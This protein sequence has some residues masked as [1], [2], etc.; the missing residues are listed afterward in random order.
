[1]PNSVS[2]PI[3]LRTLMARAYAA[4]PSARRFAAGS[5]A[6]RHDHPGQEQ[7]DDDDEDDQQDLAHG[8]HLPY[9]ADGPWTLGVSWEESPR[10]APA[11]TGA[12]SRHP[13]V[14][15]RTVPGK[16]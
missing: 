5:A 16:S 4:A 13:S 11:E 7:H 15:R 6:A 2:V 1:M 3:T 12:P 9:G 10:P 14:A 8:T